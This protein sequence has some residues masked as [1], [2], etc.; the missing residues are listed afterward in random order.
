MP[1][2]PQGQSNLAALTVPG[3][4]VEIVKPQPFLNGAPTNQMAIVGV[5]SWGPLDT[6]IPFSG[7]DACARLFGEPIDRKYDLATHV[8][9]SAQVGRAISYFGVRV[10]DGTDTAAS[11]NIQSGCM[12]LTAK[13]SGSN[14]NGIR[15]NALQGTAFGSY[16][17]VIDFPGRPPEHFNNIGMGVGAVVVV[18]GTGWTSVPATSVT[19]APAGGKGAVVKAALVVSGTPSISAGGT[20]YAVNDL[21][22]LTNGVILRVSTVSSGAI[23]GL[24]VIN[25]GQLTGGAVPTNPVAQLSTSGA[26]TGGTFTLV[27]VLGQPVVEEPGSGYLVAPTIGLTGGGGTGGSYTVGLS[28]WRNLVN[29][30]NNGA[31]DRPASDVVTATLGTANTAPVLATPVT[32]AGGTD[33]ALAV[34]D[35]TLIGSDV[36]PRKGMYSL[37]RTKIDGFALVDH[38]TYTQWLVMNAFCKEEACWAGVA[39]PAGGSLQSAVDTRKLAAA[40][41]EWLWIS[42]GDWPSFYDSVN[43]RTR[44]VSPTAFM[45][46][47]AGNSSPE[48]SPLNKQLNGVIATQRSQVGLTY[49]DGELAV[50][51]NGGVDVIVGPPTTPGGDYFAFINGRNASSNTAAN[52]IEWTRLT[53]WLARSFHSQAAGSIVGRLQSLRADDRTRQDAKALIDGFLASIKDPSVGSHGNGI[54]EDFATVCDE[55]N[56]PVQT[57]IRG[58]LFLYAAVK[59]LNTVRF[60]VIKLA[61][62]GTVLVTNQSTPPQISQFF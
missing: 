3:P 8:W 45:L 11:A 40:D 49:S 20:G 52:G 25:A 31:S 58:Y 56:N 46:G 35:A 51:I 44:L 36:Y 29:A 47:W 62:G 6:P 5:A 54:I 30:I 53:L 9:A 33:G 38:S 21:I 32:L 27:W 12:T 4:Y 39:A 43:R 24:V 2:L 50:A 34:T 14:G 7:V 1:I 16:L 59:Y 60:F 26:G 15:Y 23:T 22:Y 55:S 42:A 57:I 19:A 10:S 37:R 17:F 28:P 61:G 13:Y 41:T 18:P 48:Q